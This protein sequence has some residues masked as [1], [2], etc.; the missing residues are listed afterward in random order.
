MEQCSPRLGRFQRLRWL[1][2][3]A[4]KKLFD[5]LG[6]QSDRQQASGRQ[7]ETSKYDDGKLQVGKKWPQSRY[8]VDAAGQPDLVKCP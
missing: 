8:L 3:Y 2:S 1:N 4:I 6:F 5:Q 7:R